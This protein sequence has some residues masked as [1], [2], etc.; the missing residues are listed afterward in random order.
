MSIRKNMSAVNSRLRF[1]KGT[2]GDLLVQKFPLIL[3]FD[4]YCHLNYY[5]VTYLY[6][7]IKI[8]RKKLNMKLKRVNYITD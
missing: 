2:E 3:S 7:I 1:F 8:K 6:V 5:S 4:Y